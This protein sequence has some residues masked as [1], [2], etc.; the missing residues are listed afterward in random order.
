MRPANFVILVVDDD[1]D[2]RLMVERAFRHAGATCPICGLSGGNEALAYLEGR[3]PYADRERFPYPSFIVTDL[4]MACGDGFTVLDYL[5]QHPRSRIIPTLVLTA[6]SHPDDV[7]TSYR[8]GASAY[9]VKPSELEV[10][11]KV[12]RLFYQFWMACEVP[13]VDA[14]GHWVQTER[15]GRLGDRFAQD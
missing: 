14:A 8:L 4:H 5:T 11:R 9:L 12:L 13:S 7:A 1:S 10:L 6:S 2:D 3:D 15:R